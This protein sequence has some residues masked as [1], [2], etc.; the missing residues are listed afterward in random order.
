MTRVRKKKYGEREHCCRCALSAAAVTVALR[1]NYDYFA[2]AGVGESFF[3]SLIDRLRGGICLV[4]LRSTQWGMKIGGGRHGMVH[5]VH[6]CAMS[7]LLMIG[8]S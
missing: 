7:V 3:G 2:R 1:K 4:E 6:L 8:F 5:D